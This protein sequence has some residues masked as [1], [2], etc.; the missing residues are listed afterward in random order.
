ML[1][2]QISV[3]NIH[4]NEPYDIILYNYDFPTLLLQSFL[5]QKRTAEHEPIQRNDSFNSFALFDS[6]IFQMNLIPSSQLRSYH[7]TSRAVNITSRKYY[8][9]NRIAILQ[10]RD[11]KVDIIHI[12]R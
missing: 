4:R 6:Y 9:I 12:S 5:F 1:P 8:V 7:H 3:F 10:N 2:N 11:I